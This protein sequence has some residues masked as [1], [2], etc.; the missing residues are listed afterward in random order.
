MPH[1]T[2]ATIKRLPTPTKGN[3]VH[4]DDAIKG[5]GARVT[6]QGARSFVLNYTTAGGRERR[7]TMGSCDDWPTAAARTEAKRLRQ[8][9]DQGGDPLANVEDERTAPTVAELC[10]RFEAE[11]AIRKRPSTVDAYRRQI[12]NHIRPMIGPR[13]VADIA[14]TDVDRLHRKVTATAGPY[15]ANRTV[16][17]L[18]KMFSLAIRWNM[19]PDNPAKGVERNTEYGRRRYLSAAE[20]IALTQALADYADQQVANVFRVLLLTGCRKSEALAMRW[21]DVDLTT[22]VWSKPAASVKQKEDHEVPLS[23]PARLLLSEI[24]QQQTGR[25]QVLGEYVF[26][27]PGVTGHLVAI[28]K[29]WRSICQS[30]GIAELRIHDLRHSFASQLVSG[31]ASLPLVG[32]LLGHSSPLTTAR[33]AHLHHDPQRAA[34]ETV[35]AIVGAAASKRR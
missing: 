24:R 34:V 6:A 16:A 7:Y 27:G 10:D 32:A 14:F 23:G 9:V 31:G 35:G 3:R 5:F 28:K 26:P 8:V 21:G 22:G 30:A 20:L 13:K 19:R 18:S 29:A 15:A 33:Y 17:L 1:L 11:H 2:D 25:R 12:T 4:Y